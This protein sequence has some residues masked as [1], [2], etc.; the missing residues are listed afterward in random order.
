MR[1]RASR[2]IVLLRERLDREHGGDREKWMLALLPLAVPVPTD[3]WPAATVTAGTSKV[4][5]VAAVACLVVLAAGTWLAVTRPPVALPA[6][7]SAAVASGSAAT[8]SGDATRAEGLAAAAAKA[9]ATRAEVP[10]QNAAAAS[11]EFLRGVVLADD[12]RAIANATVSVWAT[13]GYDPRPSRRI[14]LAHL[15]TDHDGSFRV[16]LA[17]ALATSVAARS[18][19]QICVSVHAAGYGNDYAE[20]ELVHA[21]TKAK[22]GPEETVFDFYLFETQSLN[23]RVLGPGGL[24]V[25]EAKL[26][27]LASSSEVTSWEADRDGRFQLELSDLGEA[28]ADVTIIASHPQFGTSQPRYARLV[29]DAVVGDLVL[30]P[31]AT[32]IEGQLLWSDGRPVA[33]HEVLWEFVGELDQARPTP[34]VAVAAGGRARLASAAGG[35]MRTD[36]DGRFVLAHPVVGRH[37]F[38]F[39]MS[40]EPVPA[41][42]RKGEVTRVTHTLVD[43]DVPAQIHVAVV[44]QH[45]RHL[46]RARLGLRR[47]RG[48]AAV[49]A[50]RRYALEGP[51]QKLLA[52][53]T[54]CETYVQAPEYVD[55]FPDSFCVLEATGHSAGPDYVACRLAPGQHRQDVRL[56]VRPRRSMSGVHVTVVDPAGTRIPGAW[57]RVCRGKPRAAVPILLP[58]TTYR[59]TPLTWIYGPWHMLPANGRIMGLPPGEL[60]FEFFPGAVARSGYT[61]TPWPLETRSI[62]VADGVVA[63]LAITTRRGKPLR[64]QVSVAG[65]PDGE[66]QVSASLRPVG[67]RL[68]YEHLRDVGGARQP[69]IVDGNAMAVGLR[70]YPR[71]TY[72]LVVRTKST[73]IAADA[74]SSAVAKPGQ[75]RRVLEFG[76]DDEP[77]VVRML[78]R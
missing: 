65:M 55:A 4:A 77:I 51:S 70:R 9:L 59:N 36:N 45:G 43:E 37:E 2:A 44:D 6:N 61:H 11:P 52:T 8:A 42:V 46:P 16:P 22:G 28:G 20:E 64:I 69:R 49:T 33:N 76:N 21:L 24:A 66:L 57:F 19:M 31:H 73:L 14:E 60:T 56:V 68:F 32:R 71:G 17:T 1:V 72:E 74:T 75:W 25:P 7:G 27:L 35:S 5:K 50:E 47:W 23:G 62:T 26:T 18:Q 78:R 13:V 38:S 40:D 30:Q 58:G 48:A 54:E 53:A 63:P 29:G 12:D 15:Q 67:A 41:I 39:D 34:V 3:P 10:P